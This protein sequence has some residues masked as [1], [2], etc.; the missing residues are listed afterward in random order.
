MSSRSTAI[1]GEQIRAAR[2][3]ARLEQAELARRCGLSLETIK[4][5]ERIRGPVDANT[6][7]LNAIIGAFDALGIQFDGCEDGGVGVCRLPDRMVA[8]AG[9][10]R[11]SALEPGTQRLRRL[12]FHSAARPAP[13]QD[14]KALLDDIG[15]SAAEQNAPLGITG[16]LYSSN[17]RFLQVLEGPKDA[18]RQVFGAI[19]CDPRHGSVSVIEDRDIAIRLFPDWVL[20]CGQFA[21]DGTVL[22]DEPV[23]D[24]GFRPETL[25]PAAALGLL[26]VVRDLQ[27]TAPRIRRP[28]SGACPLAGDCL[29]ENCAVRTERHVT[30]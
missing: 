9:R 29:D 19:S 5:L 21:S 26:G 13:G 20:C 27:A 1:T 12:I 4:R 14:V 18:V 7:T 30:A 10:F 6:R 2:A 24:G 3:L 17:A 11:M 23:F 28:A 15:K 22:K 8:E 25:S 16:V